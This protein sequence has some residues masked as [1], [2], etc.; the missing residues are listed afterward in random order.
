MA[1]FDSYTREELRDEIV[2][3]INHEANRLRDAARIAPNRRGT[4]KNLRVAEAF[5]VLAMN[6]KATKFRGVSE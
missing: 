5:E 6:L 1:Y 3:T 4:L 2:R